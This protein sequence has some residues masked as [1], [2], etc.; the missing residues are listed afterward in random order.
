MLFCNLQSSIYAED[1]LGVP[2]SAPVLEFYTYPAHYASLD[3]SYPPFSSPSSSS[4]S[5]PPPAFE[6]FELTLSI[7]RRFPSQACVSDDFLLRASL[8]RRLLRYCLTSS[9]VAQSFWQRAKADAPTIYGQWRFVFRSSPT[10]L[11]K[12]PRSLTGCRRYSSCTSSRT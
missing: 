10:I 8:L 2:C 12:S 9:A 5:L 1:S 6:P 7:W 4:S 11:N 3:H